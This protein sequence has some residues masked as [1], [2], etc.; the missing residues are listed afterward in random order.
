MWCVQ[1]VK[2][3]KMNPLFLDVENFVIAQDDDQQVVGFG[4]IRPLGMSSLLQAPAA[5]NRRATR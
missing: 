2:D 3:E 1:M 4:Q 5:A